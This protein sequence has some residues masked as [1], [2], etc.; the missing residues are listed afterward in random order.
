MSIVP[1]NSG[2]NGVDRRPPT[3]DCRSSPLISNVW[4]VKFVSIRGTRGQ[5]KKKATNIEINIILAV[6]HDYLINMEI[7]IV[8]RR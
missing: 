1:V 7:T 3:A 4:V 2:P 5:G 6:I 8:T